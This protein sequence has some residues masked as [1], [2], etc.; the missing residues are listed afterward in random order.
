MRS[1]VVDRGANG[2]DVEYG[3]GRIDWAGAK[4]W[5]GTVWP[6]YP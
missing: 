5:T 1:K 3:Y 2:A 4:S 6:V